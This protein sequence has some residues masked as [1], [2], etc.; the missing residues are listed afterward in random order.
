MQAS[1]SLHRDV[2]KSYRFAERRD[3][4]RFSAKTRLD[5]FPSGKRPGD[6]GYIRLSRAALTRENEMKPQSSHCA[7]DQRQQ[8]YQAQLRQ[9]STL[10]DSNS[11]RAA[12]CSW[13]TLFHHGS[14]L[15]FGYVHESQL[16][17][18]FLLYL[19]YVRQ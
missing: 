10:I 4:R 1:A 11:F 8:L 2:S 6:Y 15:F 9:H 13:I 17:R 18:V 5:V 12:G 16:R 3:A 19:L 14:S 7:G